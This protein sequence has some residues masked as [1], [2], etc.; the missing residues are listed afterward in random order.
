MRN[1]ILSVLFLG[2]SSPV[3][4]QNPSPFL[5]LP[6]IEQLSANTDFSE[7]WQAWQAKDYIKA[8]ILAAQS[9][10]NGESAGQLLFGI[11]LDKGLGGDQ[12]PQNAVRWYREAATNGETDAWLALAGM[13]FEQRGGL[14]VSDGRQFLQNAANENNPEAMW[15]LGQIFASGHG[16]PL[17][18]KQAEFWFTA[19]INKGVNPARISLADLYL[20][21]DKPEQALRLYQTAAFGG[22]AEAAWKAGVLQAD[23]E[24]VVYAPK[25][26]NQHL[27]TAAQSG[28]LQAMTAYGLFL[29]GRT[30]P[31]P[32]SAARW[33]RKA[34]EASHAEGQ[35]LFALS[36]AKGE[37]IEEDRELAYEWALRAMMNDRLRP[38]YREL[39][40]ALAQELPASVRDMAHARSKMPLLISHAT[41][42]GGIDR[43]KA[44][45]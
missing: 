19:A 17:D 4:A 29:A 2:L 9:G 5:T 12:D 38:E 18:E 31:L 28:D 39:A 21:Q 6:N 11:L 26:A 43:L 34:A 37:G 16:G 7:A 33:F 40:N 20:A 36:L 27:L 35:Y 23:P 8:R 13:A 3:F 32:A 44:A 42:P 30:P 14:S 10:A 41:D 15:A 22:S 25:K 1:F 24:S 45:D